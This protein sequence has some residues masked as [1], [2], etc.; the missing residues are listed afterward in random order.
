[1]DRE[2]IDVARQAWDSLP[3]KDRSIRKVSAECARLGCPVSR[4][5]I[6]RWARVWKEGGDLPRPKPPVPVQHSV[7][8]IDYGEPIMAERTSDGQKVADIPQVIMD[9]IDP[10]VSPLLDLTKL[11]RAEDSLLA[12]MEEIA[13]RKEL[14]VDN[15]QDPEAETETIERTEGKETIKKVR[16]GQRSREAFDMLVQGMGAVALSHRTKANYTTG[17]R[18]LSQG[19]MLR[20]A[21]R[22]SEAKAQAI[23]DDGRPNR[24]KEIDG[25]TIDNDDGDE[26]MQALRDQAKQK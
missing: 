6:Q 21:G 26:A 7:E 16:K 23:F 12:V 4:S 11:Q 14:L 5:N 8:I 18:D 13:R 25:K 10:R 15:L 17:Y 1:M 20:G 19:D 2:Q 3:P 24:A 9:A 22:K